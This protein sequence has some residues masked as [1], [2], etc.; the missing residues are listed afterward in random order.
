MGIPGAMSMSQGLPPGT[1]RSNASAVSHLSARSNM[2]QARL[3]KLMRLQHRENSK[4]RINTQRSRSQ[5]SN[6]NPYNQRPIT[7]M[8][9]HSQHL[10][11]PTRPATG[12]SFR[13][14][15]I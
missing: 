9:M 7:G 13:D 6:R 1:A 12:M 10:P 14:Q 5:T 2:S 11:P 8:S 3:E 4:P 15:N